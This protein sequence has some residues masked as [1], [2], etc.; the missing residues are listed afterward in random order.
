[1]TP[2]KWT[3]TATRLEIGT[4]SMLGT[5][6]SW[7]N[8]AC[9]CKLADMHVQASSIDPKLI[10]VGAIWFRPCTLPDIGN[11]QAIY[12]YFAISADFVGR[13]QGNNVK[14]A[15]G[16]GIVAPPEEIIHWQRTFKESGASWI[17]WGYPVK[18]EKSKI[19]INVNHTLGANIDHAKLY[20]LFE[21]GMTPKQVS[22]QTGLIDESVRY[23]WHKWRNGKPAVNGKG[24]RT[25]PVDH[26]AIIE[27][28]RSGMF[29]MNEIAQR[30]DTTRATVWKTKKRFG[31]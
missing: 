7:V 27:D 2:D 4:N 18:V 5:P 19:T 22:N 30:N 8:R 10:T 23:I 9:G 17:W 31:L 16:M 1:M 28:V 15:L 26:D 24:Q 20:S 25:K 14:S 11:R 12:R 29:S 6:R 21:Q 3:H 13:G